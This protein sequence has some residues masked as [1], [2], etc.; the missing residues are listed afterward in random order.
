MQEPAGWLEDVFLGIA[1]LYLKLILSQNIQSWKEPTR[2]IECTSEVNGPYMDQTPDPGVIL[3]TIKT[4][5][6][7]MLNITAEQE[8]TFLLAKKLNKLI[9]LPIF[10]HFGQKYLLLI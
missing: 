7:T 5:V 3:T 4:G 8:R 6:S 2:I 9:Y 10:C 1:Q